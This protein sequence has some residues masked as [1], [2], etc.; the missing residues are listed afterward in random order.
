MTET[1]PASDAPQALPGR[2]LV[3]VCT[4]NE[5]ENLPRLI[6]A[7]LEEAPDVDLL[8]VDDASPDGTGRI[9]DEFSR[10]DHRVR[11]LHRT[12][13]LGLGT[14]ILAG[15]AYG[16]DQGYDFVLNMDADFSHHPRHLPALRG[17]MSSADVGIGSRYVP[18][19]G[20]VGW[21]LTRRLMSRAI[22]LYA[23]WLLGIAARDTS[24]AYRCYRM[25]KL[26]ELDFSKVRARGYS[27]QEE[28]LYRCARIGCR[29]VETPILFEDRRA[30]ASKIN[31]KESVGAGWIIF[32][33]SLDRLFR[34][35]VR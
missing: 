33:L 25:A 34:V 12:G 28:I 15:L 3:T 19:G 29:M 17:V 18:G 6:P 5:A 32:R 7:I 16:R 24:G 30:G 13:K 10:A 9:A 23:R 1:S 27:F 2:W 14:A 20:T 4:Y 35:S 26:K 31:W 22:N 21:S 8:V 11:A